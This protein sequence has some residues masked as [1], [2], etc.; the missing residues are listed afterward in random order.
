[1]EQRE[2]MPLYYVN[3]GR[4]LAQASDVCLCLGTRV[5]R[6]T[7]P[8]LTLALSWSFAA[9]LWEA[10]GAALAA[11]TSDEPAA[12]AP[13]EA[14][15]HVLPPRFRLAQQRETVLEARRNGATLRDIAEDARVGL[16]VVAR[17]LEHEGV[18]TT[19]RK[20]VVGYHAVTIWALRRQGLPM[21]QIARQLG[22]NADSLT[23]WCKRHPVPAE[24]E[25]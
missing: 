17:F 22:L 15:L 12:L 13:D 5:G 14:Q 11:C 3:Q 18:G 10:L 2:S 24:D 7:Q 4:V 23:H 1:M 19:S 6:E 25:G 8:L 16:G 9:H 21:A 20:D